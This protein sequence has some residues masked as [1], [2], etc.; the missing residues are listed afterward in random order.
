MLLK[1]LDVTI[2]S[3]GWSERAKVFS[4]FVDLNIFIKDNFLVFKKI[5]Y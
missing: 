3:F 4:L 1:R 5:K 2:D